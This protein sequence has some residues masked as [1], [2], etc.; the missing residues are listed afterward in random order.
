MRPP[1]WYRGWESVCQY[2]GY[3]FDPQSGKIPHVKEQ[4]KPMH[5]NYGAHTLQLLKP[6]HLELML[7]NKRSHHSEKHV[8]HN[9]E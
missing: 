7:C 4:L 2:R 9:K 8:P 5:H 1:W 6:V 3:G